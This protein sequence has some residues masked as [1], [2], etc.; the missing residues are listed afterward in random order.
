MTC[1]ANKFNMDTIT[2]SDRAACLDTCSY[3]LEIHALTRHTGFWVLEDISLETDDEYLRNALQFM[4]SANEID[5]MEARAKTLAKKLDE[6]IVSEQCTGTELLRRLIIKNGLYCIQAAS[7]P[8][9][10]IRLLKYSLGSKYKD[11]L[12]WFYSD[13]HLENEL[14]KR[15][16]DKATDPESIDFEKTILSL[17]ED[18]L[19]KAYSSFAMPAHVFKIALR[20]CSGECIIN[21]LDKIHE[22]TLLTIMIYK[23]ILRNM[24]ENKDDAKALIHEKQEKILQVAD[25][26]Y[27][28]WYRSGNARILHL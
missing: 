19:N 18:L 15:I 12:S 23:N 1:N 22:R 2:D 20:G 27:Q 16:R 9:R 21:V 26:N 14:K 8:S 3:I 28:N 5:D 11:K 17:D 25:I 13:E 4:K 10:I 24:G 6:C 7:H